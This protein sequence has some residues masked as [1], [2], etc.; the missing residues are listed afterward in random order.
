MQADEPRNE[1]VNT[2]ENKLGEQTTTK[3][4]DKNKKDKTRLG[5]YWT[6]QAPLSKLVAF[7]YQKGCGK[8]APREFLENY[9]VSLQTDGYAV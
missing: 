5:Y 6:Y 7:N 2:I 1:L 9:K 3:I 4:L 8:D